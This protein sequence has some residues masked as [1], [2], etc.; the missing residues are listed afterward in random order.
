MEN[1]L[2]I[3]LV[4]PSVQK[5][6]VNYSNA[7]SRFALKSIY[8][9]VYLTFVTICAALVG[10]YFFDIHPTLAKISYSLTFPI[11]LMMIVFL[12]AELA[13]SNMMYMTVGVHQK[14]LDFKKATLI[15]LACTLFNLMGATITSFFMSRTGNAHI[16]TSDSFIMT[17]VDA[18]LSKDF[19]TLFIEA[20]LANIFVNIAILGQLKTNNDL[21]KLFFIEV[22]IFIFV[23]LG[24]EHVIANFGLYTMALFTGNQSNLG[25]I[26][27]HWIIVFFGNIIGGGICM[28]L[29][30]SWLNSESK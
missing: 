27:I 17:M 9:G 1:N 8:A 22:A 5:K 15:I 2:F 19:L 30:Y 7:F 21:A 23:F 26:I 14:W 13:T 12:N 20:I 11:G 4:K 29:G 6:E 18:K 24:Y 10:T 28:G 16:M 25:L 3:S